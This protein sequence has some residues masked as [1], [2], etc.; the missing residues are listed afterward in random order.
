MNANGNY[1]WNKGYL[2]VKSVH[3]DSGT[4][5]LGAE[6]LTAPLPPPNFKQKI[7]NYIM[8]VAFLSFK[9]SKSSGEE[10]SET[11]V[12]IGTCGTCL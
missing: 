4:A 8:T 9:V 3:V 11:P 7:N 2:G 1:L 12:H 5:E 10:F 6:G